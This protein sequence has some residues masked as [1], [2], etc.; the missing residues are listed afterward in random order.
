MSGRP[1]EQTL[2]P[3]T[4]KVKKHLI[5][6]NIE[7]VE[8]FRIFPLKSDGGFDI[9]YIPDFCLKNHT[10]QSSGVFIVFIPEKTQ[11]SRR[12]NSVCSWEPVTYRPL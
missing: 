12:L 8:H 2:A 11:K 6:A 9:R 10:V 4:D 5:G 1:H 3:G 7:F